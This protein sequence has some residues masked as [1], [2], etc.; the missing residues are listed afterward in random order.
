MA[1]QSWVS[2][3]EP[4][5]I[6]DGAA[7]TTFTAYQDISPAPAL[8]VPANFLVPGTR[9]HLE[10]H[11]EF[12]NTGT[13]TLSVGFFWGT[14]AVPLGQSTLITTTTAA[15]SWPWAIEY[16]G[17]VRSIGTAGSIWGKGK[18]DLGTS[19]VAMT[20]QFTPTT[21][22][23]RTSAIDTTIEKVVG[24]GAQWGTSSASNTIKVNM[25]SVWF[26]N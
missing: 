5:H 8:K 26:K 13:P 14:A 10:A 23:L 2:L 17:V 22:A 20:S 11:G 3:L 7:F 1:H 15:T 19:L 18:F 12:G 6:L 21:L 9:L 16:D 24:V 4:C 25:F